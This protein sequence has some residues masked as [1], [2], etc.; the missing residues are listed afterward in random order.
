MGGVLR[1]AGL[2][3]ASVP[4]DAKLVESL[5]ASGWSPAGVPGPK[6]GR[7]RAVTEARRWVRCI[8]GNGRLNGVCWSQLHNYR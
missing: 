1:S 5:G 3:D 6:R 4:A 8:K 7:H 2:T